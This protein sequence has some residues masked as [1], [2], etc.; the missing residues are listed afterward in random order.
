MKHRGHRR[1][2]SGMCDL[3]SLWWRNVTAAA[4]SMLH[5]GWR[6]RTNKDLHS[7]TVS[8]DWRALVVEPGTDDKQPVQ[9]ANTL[10]CLTNPVA[11]EEVK[12]AL[13]GVAGISGPGGVSWAS[14][15]GIPMAALSSLFNTLKLAGE[16]LEAIA[17]RTNN[18]NSQDPGTWW[19]IPA[20]PKTATS[21]V[22]RL[23]DRI[24][25][26]CLEPAITINPRQN[27]FITGD[28]VHTYVR[29]C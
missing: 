2:D 8:T 1:S 19:A 7:E 4:R 18:F 26:S 17:K 22:G 5:G 16:V 29:A 13:V 23:Y 15:K 11:P 14:L 9:H 12:A 27:G 25:A 20:T 10:W 28:G 3:R 6:N 24:L 21:T